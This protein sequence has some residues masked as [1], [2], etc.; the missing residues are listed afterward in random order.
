MPV[1]FQAVQTAAKRIAGQVVPSPCPLSIPL[2]E[3]TGL[4]IYCKLEYL[5]RT[6]SFKERGARNKLLLLDPEQR[7]RGVIAASAGNHALGVAYH[8]QLLGIPAT[9]VMPRFAP[10]MKA[11]N[12]RRLGATVVL[13]GASIADAKQRADEIADEQ[14]L[15]Y[16]HGY[17]DPDIIAGQGTLGLEIAAQVPDVD[18]V[19]VPI[20][21]AGLVAGLGLALK[22]LKPGVQILGVEP[23]GAASFT[24]AM[25]AGRP[26]PVELKPTLADGLSVPQVGANAFEVARRVVDKTL[27]VREHDIALAILRL[28]ELEKAVV[29]GAG[30]APLAVCLAGQVPELAGRTVVL[31]LCGGNIDTPILGRVLERGLASD[32]RLFHFTTTISD[33]PGGLARFAAVLAETEASI[34]EVAHDRAFASDDITT[35]SVHCV[36]ETRD[37]D[38][39][40][41]VRATLHREG[42]PVTEP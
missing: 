25:R 37:L 17:D 2:S 1:T 5:Q 19:I 3:A 16:I 28:L 8:A 26:V 32:G 24:A 33:R 9:V 11:S 36:L 21:G 15:T 4:K 30:A 38:H 6:G 34:L 23:E 29:E 13:E 12:C 41:A 22:T 40:A 27:L 7:Q 14:A 35:V 20:G 42:F 18:A 39:I 10:L 31:P